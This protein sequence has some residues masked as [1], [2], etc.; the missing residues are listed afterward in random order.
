MDQ[1]LLGFWSV[2]SIDMVPDR[3]VGLIGGLPGEL[4]EFTSD[5]TYVVW[6]DPSRP[7]T[8]IQHCRWHEKTDPPEVDIWISGLESLAAKCVYRFDEEALVIGIAGNAGPRPTD[9]RRDDDRLWC[10]VTLDRWHGPPP[11][12]RRRRRRPLLKRGSLIPE[13]F[14]DDVSGQESGEGRQSGRR[15]TRKGARDRR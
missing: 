13:G 12:K 15:T 6:G 8:T 7:H 2:R 4:V 3:C 14:L 10:V 11:A 1:R 5:D 9:I